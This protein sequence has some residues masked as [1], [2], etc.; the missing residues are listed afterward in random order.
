L[1]ENVKGL[2]RRSFAPYVEFVELQLASPMIVPKS[3]NAAGVNAWR[4]HLPRL[5]KLMKAPRSAR[6]EL[7]YIVSKRLLNAAD[8]GVP[9]KRE[10]V[11]IVA[12]RDDLPVEWEGVTPT[13][14]R[15]S[16]LHDLWVTRDY[17]ERHRVPTRTRP[18]LPKEIAKLI[19]RLRVEG[20]P[21]GL[22]SWRTVRDA[23]L[24]L[25]EPR[26][27]EPYPGWLNHVGQ[28]G[29][30]SYPG[31]TGSPL[32]EP[33]KTLKAGGHGVP[34]GENMLRRLDGSIRYFTVREA[35]RLQT[36]PDDYH[37]E[38]AW[39]EALRQLGNAVPVRLAEAV[40]RSLIPLLGM[41]RK[42]Q[43]R[44]ALMSPSN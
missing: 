33:A 15:S 9:Q 19:D 34:G 18:P 27:H 41:M 36:F 28:P 37:V 3:K 30:R 23:L 39:G 26:D 44:L 2:M 32:D 25:P 17:W 10:R 1:I 35:A 11:F 13:H 21:A 42:R 4:R 31:H 6:G 8:F 38:G 22:E 24:G 5:K 43:P 29:A 7:R 14:D 20:K 12:V 40:T 16:L